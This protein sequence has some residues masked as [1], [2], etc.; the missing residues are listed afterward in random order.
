MSIANS[1]SL[2]SLP[3][4]TVMSLWLS[5]GWL[6]VLLQMFHSWKG[7]KMKDAMILLSNILLS[8][9]MTHQKRGTVADSE[10]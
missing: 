4:M 9:T 2:F 7:V 5:E 10:L 1:I 6:L 3:L 8:K